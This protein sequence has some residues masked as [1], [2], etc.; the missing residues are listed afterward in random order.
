[1][2]IT[3]RTKN[4]PQPA[5]VYRDIASVEQWPEDEIQLVPFNPKQETVVVKGLDIISLEV[6]V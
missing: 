1:M 2:T 3:L 5:L 6:Q 4:N